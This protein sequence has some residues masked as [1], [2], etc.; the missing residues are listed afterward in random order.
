MKCKEFESLIDGYLNG[1]LTEEK[2]GDFE[3][4]YFICDHCF[5]ILKTAELLYEKKIRIP[6]REK[7]NFS[8]S[9]R[10]SLAFASVA[11]LI[12]V[13][14]FFVDTDNR[15]KRISRITSFTPPL[16]IQAE[17]R[18][19]DDFAEFSEAMRKYGA[20]DYKT[21]YSIISS[22]DDG[23][24]QVW[25]FKGILALL[26]DDPRNALI[27][28]SSIVEAM[29]PSYYDEAVFYRGICYIRLNR[30]K[31]ALREFRNLETMYSPFSKKAADMISLMS[32]I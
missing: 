19:G 14:L 28:F 29:D 8:L 4:H 31:D 32:G 17:N 13:S 22:I 27:S 30:N 24:P 7:R 15:N 10:P 12:F 26:N 5:S 16:Y 3:S 9:L 21:A 23:N 18:G 11:V 25:F 20:G 1:T 2:T 6:E